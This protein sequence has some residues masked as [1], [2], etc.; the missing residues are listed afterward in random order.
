MST[1]KVRY[2]S[3]KV[4]HKFP[5]PLSG[6]GVLPSVIHHVDM[7]MVATVL[8]LQLQHDVPTMWAMV[9]PKT[10]TVTKAFQ[11]VGTGDEVSFGGKYIGT[12]QLQGGT[13]VFHLYDVGVA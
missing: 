7:P 12:V 8:T 9:D 11:W 6:W 3:G 5:L 1:P 4:I 10:P 13:Y 2:G